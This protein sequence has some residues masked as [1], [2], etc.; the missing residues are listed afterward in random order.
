MATYRSL[1]RVKQLA[2]K[3]VQNG[4]AKRWCKRVGNEGLDNI[5]IVVL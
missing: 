3:K 5:S 2:N 1:Q 4:I